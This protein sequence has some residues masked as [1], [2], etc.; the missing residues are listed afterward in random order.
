MGL[1][2][3]REWNLLSKFYSMK[4]NF[5]GYFIKT[6]QKIIGQISRQIKVKSEEKERYLLLSFLKKR[7]LYNLLDGLFF[8]HRINLIFKD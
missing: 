1:Y 8:H 3:E 6:I 2:Q 7:N 5:Q 4:I